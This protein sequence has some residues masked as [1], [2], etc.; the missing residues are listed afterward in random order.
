M[1]AGQQHQP[2]LSTEIATVLVAAPLTGPWFS[3]VFVNVGQQPE[4]HAQAY[5]S[6]V[7]SAA[8]RNVDQ[9][10]AVQKLHQASAEM[11]SARLL[12]GR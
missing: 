10:L 5:P 12:D 3:S 2:V 1:I 8:G 11:S 9:T 7:V 6:P 4:P